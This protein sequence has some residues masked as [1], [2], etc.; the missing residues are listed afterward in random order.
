[1][2]IGLIAII[3]AIIVACVA[4]ILM[5]IRLQRLAEEKRA[6]KLHQVADELG[7]EFWPHGDAL[8]LSS[9]GGFR[10]F[11][12]GHSKRVSNLLRGSSGGR[13]VDIFEYRYTTGSGKSTHHWRQSV[14]R[15][16]LDGAALPAFSLRPEHVWHKIGAWFGY[17]DID[18]DAY[19]AFSRKYLLRGN[20]EN[21]IRDL[22]TNEVL[23]YYEQHAGLSTEGAGDT[24]LFYRHS[25]RVP[26][27]KLRGFIEEGLK[28]LTLFC[29]QAEERSAS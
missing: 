23:A 29:P 21:A 17:Q 11:S 20:D 24:L 18:F 28:V 4:V 12:Q 25:R 27:E 14:I 10:L 13:E 3:A 9:L 1:M 6:R 5:A 7:L 16:R 2:D 15:F 19:P 26:P 22:F 8:L